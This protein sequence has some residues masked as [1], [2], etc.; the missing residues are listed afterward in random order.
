MQIKATE[1]YFPVVLFVTVFKVVLTVSLRTKSCG[2]TFQIK[3]TQ[4]YF[5]MVLFA[6][7]HFT[8][9]KLEILSNFFF[10]FVGVEELKGH[11]ENPPTILC[12][13]REGNLN[14]SLRRSPHVRESKTILDSGFH[15]VDSRFQILLNSCYG[16]HFGLSYGFFASGVRIPESNS[17]WDSGFLAPCGWKS[18]GFRNPDFLTLHERREQAI[19]SA[20][21]ANKL[22]VPSISFLSVFLTGI[23]N[24]SLHISPI[25]A[26]DYSNF[27]NLK[28]C[29]TLYNPSF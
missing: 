11:D 16:F 19:I 28:N 12:K 29:L 4:Q 20:L 9:W 10:L 3:A 21:S 14:H 23:V 6:F 2:V 13:T 17:Y 15:A 18:P 5:Q 22:S 24:M 27:N 8:K 7:Q 26:V 25:K 1:R